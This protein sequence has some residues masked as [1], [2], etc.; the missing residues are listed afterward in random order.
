MET[1]A[2]HPAI[3]ERLGMA[4]YFVQRDGTFSAGIALDHGK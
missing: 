2:Q 3:G 4:V 1:S